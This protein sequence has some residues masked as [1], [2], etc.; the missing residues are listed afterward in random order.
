MSEQQIQKRILDHLA[1]LPN[2][3]SV[4]VISANKNGVPDILA[5]VNGKFVAIEVKTPTGRVSPL[6]EYQINRINNSGGLAAVA[7]SVDDV[8]K[9]LAQL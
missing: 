9:L 7:R 6:Q 2:T 4:K 5:C 8:K 1:K 3:W